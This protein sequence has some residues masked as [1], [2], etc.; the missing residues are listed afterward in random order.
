VDISGY[1][2]RTTYYALPQGIS[3]NCPI[4]AEL[5]DFTTDLAD[6]PDCLS[7]SIDLADGTSSIC[8]WALAGD[9]DRRRGPSAPRK[10]IP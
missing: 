9:D 4:A 3:N 5:T 1:P 7:V 2:R 8:Q 10:E 6:L